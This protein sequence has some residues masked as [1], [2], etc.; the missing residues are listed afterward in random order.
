MPDTLLHWHCNGITYSIKRLNSVSG[1]LIVSG[2]GERQ[3]RGRRDIPVSVVMA[4]R[5][6]S[7]DERCEAANRE[8][9]S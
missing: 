8:I 9:D 7:V 2:P 1:I 4:W 6:M 5:S 3:R